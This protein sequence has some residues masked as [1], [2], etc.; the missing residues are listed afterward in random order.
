VKGGDVFTISQVNFKCRLASALIP[1]VCVHMQRIKYARKKICER[2]R[3]SHERSVGYGNTN[4]PSMHRRSQ[5]VATLVVGRNCRIRKI[6]PLVN[7][8]ALAEERRNK[9]KQTPKYWESLT[10][11]KSPHMTS[12]YASLSWKE[13]NMAANT[14][15]LNRLARIV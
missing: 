5:N 11:P 4:I 14:K 6:S 1:F 9:T 12:F 15:I 8:R 2:P 7:L 13:S 10:K 3:Y